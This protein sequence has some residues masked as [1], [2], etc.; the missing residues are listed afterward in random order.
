MESFP[1]ALEARMVATVVPIWVGIPEMR[2]VVE[3]ILRPVVKPVAEKVG[4]V[5]LAVIGKLL[6][7]LTSALKVLLLLVIVGFMTTFF[8]MRNALFEM[9]CL[10]PVMTQSK[11]AP[12]SFKDAAETVYVDVLALDAIAAPF[13]RHW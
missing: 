8:T 1:A 7:V 3:W 12:L 5:P 2:P 11:A 4:E 9:I 13:F 10:V 6:V